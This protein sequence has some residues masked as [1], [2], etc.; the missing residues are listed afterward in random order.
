[1]QKYIAALFLS[2]VT[3][4]FAQ[5]DTSIPWTKAGCESVKGTWITA[6][7][8]TDSGCDANHCNGL[9]FCK[10]NVTMNW[11]AAVI[12]CRSIGHQL[13]DIETACPSG[14]SS[15]GT[16][17]NLKGITSS[18]NWTITPASATQPYLADGK[19]TVY[20]D[21]RETNNRYAFCTE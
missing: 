14:I 20:G 5:A 11:W 4:T 1:M 12:W 10:S 19:V 18:G 7:S 17:A 3:S 6:H 16:C 15:G 2:L 9:S 13:T 21:R 8:A